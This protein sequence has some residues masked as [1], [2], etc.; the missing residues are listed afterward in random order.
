MHVYSRL[1]GKLGEDRQ[2]NRSEGDRQSDGLSNSS[3]DDRN[4]HSNAEETDVEGSDVKQRSREMV[5]LHMNEL[6]GA[7]RDCLMRNDVGCAVA[8]DSDSKEVVER[9]EDGDM[10]AEHEVE[11]ATDPDETKDGTRIVG[12]MKRLMFKATN[13]MTMMLSTRLAAVKTER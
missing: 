5:D 8:L 13:S 1:P 9:I 2:G 12:R 11:S 10:E 3:D 4:I 7:S 6:S